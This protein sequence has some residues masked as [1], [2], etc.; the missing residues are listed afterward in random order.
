MKK[1][2]PFTFDERKRNYEILGQEYGMS[3]TVYTA[4]FVTAILLFLDI[5]GELIKLYFTVDNINLIS[6]KLL[7]LLLFYIVYKKR[8][9]LN[10]NQLTF[11][12]GIR[13]KD[14]RK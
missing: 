1:Q 4:I 9:Y 2:L 14:K 10:R 5:F 13:W 7:A 11:L 3:L 6:I 12:S 8:Y